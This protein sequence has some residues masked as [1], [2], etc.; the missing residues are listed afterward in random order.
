MLVFFMGMARFHNQQN[1][2]IVGLVGFFIISALTHT[3][4]HIS[5]AH[6]NPILS[7]C[8][9][10]TNQI[11][12]TNSIIYVLCQMG[13]AFASGALIHM[14]STFPGK[15]IEDSIPMIN[16]DKR[17]IAVVLESISMFLLV[18][19]YNSVMNN[20]AAPKYIFG[21][22][23][24]SVYLVCIVAFGFISGGCLNPALV[25]GP[26]V[27]VNYFDDMG[28]YVLGHLIGGVIAGTIYKLFLR[29]G[30]LEDDSDPVNVNLD[31]DNV[32][33]SKTE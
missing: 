6:F 25:I 26:G 24:A 22:A 8:L 13:A 16:D 28:F 9:T 33:K 1:L 7:L 29:K 11:T 20:P 2:L 4:S 32:V 17:L 15:N 12:I 23:I 5:G 3:F 18:F 10:I 19:V 14:L 27:Y 21:V 31:N 30:D